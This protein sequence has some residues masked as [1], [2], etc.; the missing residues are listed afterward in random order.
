MMFLLIAYG[1]HPTSVTFSLRCIVSSTYWFSPPY[2]HARTLPPALPCFSLS[3]RLFLE[4]SR[5]LLIFSTL[6]ISVCLSL[7]LLY[8]SL[9]L[10]I[11]VSQM[12]VTHNGIYMNSSRS[13]GLNVQVLLLVRG[14]GE[15]LRFESRNPS[16]PA[17]SSPIKTGWCR[18]D[19]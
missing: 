13:L 16:W 12:C 6:S 17:G 5:F 8:F 9:Y 15:P 11:W 2:T 3:N 4:V 14:L 18:Y 19:N 7:S 10:S 1:L